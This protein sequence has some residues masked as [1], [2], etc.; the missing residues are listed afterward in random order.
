[1]A[2]PLVGETKSKKTSST[3]MSPQDLKTLFEAINISPSWMSKRFILKKY[4][5]WTEDDINN[6]ASMRVE[7]DQQAKIGNKIGAFK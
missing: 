3:T 7:E 1:M 5:G 2:A 6:N 4:C